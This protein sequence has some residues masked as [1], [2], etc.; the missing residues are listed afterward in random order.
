MTST[1]HAV[2]SPRQ[3][4][5]MLDT[6]CVVVDRT[7]FEANLNRMAA[8]AR[9]AGLDLRPHAKTHKSIAVGTR[10]TGLGAIGVTV[11][12]PEE[13][14]VFWRAGFKPIFLAYPPVG[15][16]KL[17]R[18][19]PAFEAGDLIVGLDDTG[20]AAE[21]GAF[22]T[23]NGTTVP[24]MF[25]VDVGMGRTGLPSGRAAADAALAVAQLTGVRLAGIYAHEGHAHGVGR[26]GLPAFS[27]EIAERLRTTA[28]LIRAA[29]QTCEIVSAGTC[30][31]SWHLSRDQG[32]TEIRPGTYVFNDVRTVVDGGAEWDDCAATVLAT[33]ISRPDPARFVIDAGSK[34]LTTAFDET[35]GYG[36]IQGIDGARLARLSEEHGI[37]TLANPSYDI[38]IGDRVTVVPIHVCVTVNMHRELF[39]IDGEE[40]VDTLVVDAGLLTR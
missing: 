11:A 33:V 26:A 10:Q 40:I 22:A 25:E 20:V 35:Y 21:L 19:R 32:V 1:A 14:M 30:L 27:R 2:R 4:L 18:L 3:R 13:A 17:S 23:R 28:E 39:V 34:T 31:T 24:V 6:P 9:S 36:L 37:V 15:E 12:K 8:H 29:G 16:H 5:E 7:R 38:R